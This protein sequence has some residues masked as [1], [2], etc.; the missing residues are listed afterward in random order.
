M[1][2]LEGAFPLY[3]SIESAKDV[4]LHWSAAEEHLTLVLKLSAYNQPDILDVVLND[5]ILLGQHID[6]WMDVPPDMA[7][8]DGN[9]NNGP[10]PA[11]LTHPD[12]D[13]S[14]SLYAN[15]VTP[16]ESLRE[17]WQLAKI[18]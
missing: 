15:T 10:N 2:Q 6:F 16:L 11:R 14:Y 4:V 12:Y 17:G 5:S 13:A 3:E 8:F 7:I 1:F 18:Q 9:I